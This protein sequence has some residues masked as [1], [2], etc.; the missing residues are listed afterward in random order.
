V[1]LNNGQKTARSA[2]EIFGVDPTTLGSWIANGLLGATRAYMRGV[3]RTWLVSYEAVENF[4]R[5]HGQYVD[6]MWDTWID[7]DA[8]SGDE[9]DALADVVK[10]L[11]E[12]LGE[13]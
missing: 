8:W 10:R 11:R 12:Q 1:F 4:I 7:A 13:R 5:D 9:L 6:K 3:H 2:A